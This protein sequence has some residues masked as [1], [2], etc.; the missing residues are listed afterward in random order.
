VNRH[1]CDVVHGGISIGSLG[2]ILSAFLLVCHMPFCVL[3]SVPSLPLPS[4]FCLG[5]ILHTCLILSWLLSSRYNNLS[6]WSLNR[7]TLLLFFLLLFLDLLRGWFMLAGSFS[8]HMYHSPV[9]HPSLLSVLG[10]YLSHKRFPCALPRC[11]CAAAHHHG[12]ARV[13]ITRWPLCCLACLFLSS[14]L[15]LIRSRCLDQSLL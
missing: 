5:L 4:P 13:R 11:V 12:F 2:F 15:R 8:L 14:R 1:A 3:P 6:M 9:P 7:T 10:A